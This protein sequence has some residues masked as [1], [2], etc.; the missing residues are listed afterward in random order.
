MTSQVGVANAIGRQRVLTKDVRLSARSINILEECSHIPTWRDTTDTPADI[1]QKDREC[2]QHLRLTDPRDDKKR[3]E[4]T[5]GGLLEGVYR[6]IFDNTAF[7]RW[8][9]D[10]QSRVLWI[11]GDP[12][13]GKTMLLCGII[14]EL[15][16]Q[17]A[18]QVVYFFCQGTD[19][20]LNKATAVLRGLVYVLVDQQSALV[21]H[22]RKKYDNAGKQLF[23]DLNAWDA[24][25]EIFQNMLRD[26]S[27]KSTYFIVDALDEC[28]TDLPQLLNLIVQT[29]SSESRAKWIV[30]SRN[31]ISIE[32]VLRLDESRTRLSLE[33][34]E[35]AE[36]VSRAVAEYIRHGVSELVEIQND[37]HLQEKVRDKMQRKANGTF[38]WV[39]LVI[40]EL[41]DENVMSWDFLK[42]L[43]EM[44]ADL[45]DLYGRMLGRIE[46]LTRGN[47]EL[48][49]R[50]LSTV[51]VA[52]HPLHLQELHL[53]SSLPEP[54]G[55]S[56]VYRC[57]EKI[58]SMCGSFLTIRDEQVFIIHQSAKDYLEEH[59][60]SRIRA[61][62]I[63]QVH[64]DL[65]TRSIEAMSST[66]RQNMYGFDYGFKPED[67]RPPQP[68]PLAPI[69]YS[70]VF[71]ADHLTGNGE[72]PQSRE[73]L[74]DDGIVFAFLEDRLLH[75]LESL[76]LLG[77]L[78]EGMHL[79]RKL[80]HIAQGLSASHQLAEFLQ[81]A[82]KFVFSHSP[83]I[84]RAP[85]QTYGSALAFSPTT[86]KVRNAQW[87]YRLPFIQTVAGIRS[88]WN[89]LRQTLEGHGGPV[90]AVAFSPDGQMLASASWDTTVRLWDSALG[91]QRQTLEG[92][93]ALVTAVAFSPDGKTLAS[94]SYD[95]AVRLWDVAT[96]SQRRTLEGHGNWVTAVAFSPD[97]K[98]LA[99]ASL[100]RTVRLWDAA[101]GSQLQTLEGHGD[102]VSTVAFSPDG[103][104]LASASRDKTVQL[105]DAATG[106]QLQTLEGHGNWIRAVTFS[107]D[108]KTLASASWDWTVRL[109]DAATGS[110][111]QTL[112]GHGD[113]VSTVAFSPDGKTL[114]SAS[115]DKTVQLWDAATGSQLQTLEGHGALVTDV[116]FS[117]DGRTLA[118]A[119][120][121]WT[122]RLWDAATG[123]QR[124]TLE[125]HGD[126]V[127]A[128]AF[129]PDGKTLASASRDKTVRL[130]D[131][132]TGSQRQTLEGHGNWVTAV[133]FSPDGKTL[134]SASLDETVRLWDA[135]TGSQ[136]Q[137]LEGHGDLVTAVAFSPDGKMLASASHDKT[138][139][140]WDAATG[141]Q[142]QMLEGHGDKVAAVAFSPDG[143]MLASASYDR[144]VRLWD[145]ATGSQRK[146]LEGHGDLVTAVAFSP[147]GKMLASA[148]WDKTIRLWDAATGSQRQT[149]EKHDDWI[150]AVAFSPDGRYLRTNY[151][152]LR[153]PSTS[154]SFQLCS[155][156]KSS[157]HALYVKN[158]WIFLDGVE[159]LWLPPEYRATTVALYGNKIVLGHL[160]GGLTFLD[161]KFE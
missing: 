148:S 50:V 7:Q 44:P 122:V 71:W 110:Q 133:A 60:G 147:D 103:K 156:K 149:L 79:I 37:K 17:A 29:S 121:D 144:T 9:D 143:K 112:E 115:R 11:K 63:R 86:S 20:R 45:K 92:H 94:A 84:D 152:S 136:L 150:S 140:L 82:D 129:S 85:M 146:T 145:A 97:G 23:E 137:T 119:S 111:L 78:P 124:Q 65:G 30:S 31:E 66:L 5:K 139:R 55:E 138:V 116:A 91:S 77:K 87:Q 120:W 99:S 70:C 88:D 10:Q 40:K 125:G 22:I 135:A 21:S 14:N 49:R 26:P 64:M 39:S 153:L 107:P 131:A 126:K 113:L 75:W 134:A 41:K 38:L 69:R 90:T 96:G 32:R 114:A 46:R 61:D 28:T 6:W 36:Q 56:S 59:D 123:S 15:Q 93:G 43:D 127:A 34:K 57:T 108:G 74:G 72:S 13:K 47:P 76:S 35:N 132:A 27:L 81:D 25:S 83:I 142:L 155:D 54:A 157:V 42:V 102:Q 109:W 158:E 159:S 101:T 33:L 89:A 62:G 160:S 154:S 161:I 73:A 98:T 130:W 95:K 58:V 104:T 51:T 67:A 52:Y 106:S 18:N 105:W 19:S 8:R 117:P 151:G 16:K 2:I 48:C 80:L 68:D 141:S 4:N 1:A 100:D 3:I 12:G 24:L 53:L 128:V 118:S